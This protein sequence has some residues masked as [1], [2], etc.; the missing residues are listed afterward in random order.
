M[1]LNEHEITHLKN[2]YTCLA[3]CL[4]L[5]KKNGDFPL[6]K[7]GEIALYGSGARQTVK[8]GTGSGEV[9]SRYFVNCEEGLENRGFTVVT[10][11]W[12]DEYDEIRKKMRADFIADIKKKARKHH[13]SV[14]GE[15]MGKVMLEGDYQL[16]IEAQCETAVYVL[17]RISGEGNDRKAE[18]GDFL[19]SE[20]EKKDLYILHQ[21]YKKLL[22]VINAGG[23]VDLSE[24]DFVD[25]ILV[26]SQLGV[27]TG[28]VLADFIL[29]KVYPS[30][31]LATTW[32]AYDNYCHEGDFGDHDDTHY[33]EGIYVG[34]RYFDS[35]G[36]K[37]MYPFGYGL[38]YADFSFET[39]DI[40]ID[41]TDVKVK[42]NVKNDSDRFAGK[43]A[44][45]I[46]VS[47]PQGRID[48][49]YQD[50]TA[51]KKTDEIL[52]GESNE[53]EISFPFTDLTS[54]DSDNHCYVL[55]K[56]DYIIRCGNSS[57]NT[58]I[59]GVIR[60]EEDV[61]TKIVKNCLGDPGF[62]DVIYERKEEEL[63][64][65]V[66]VL[67]IDLHNFKTET[68]NYDVEDEV[69]PELEDC[70]DESLAYLNIGAFN[71]KGGLLNVVGNAGVSVAGAAGETVSLFKDKGLKNIVMADGPAGLRLAKQYYVDTKGVHGVNA[72]LPESVTEYLPGIA[73]WFLK[74][75]NRTPK[76][77]E[78]F[79]QAC[80][81]IPIGTAI[82]Q[83]FNT[84]YA[85]MLGDI[86]GKEM[87]MFKIDLWLAPALNI[88]RNV[89]CGRN[90][91]YFSEDPLVSGK[92]AASITKGVQRHIGK[93]V[94]IK[95][96]AANNQENNRYGNNSLVSERAMREIYL[97][98]FEICIKEA[99]PFAIMSSYNLLNGIHTSEHMGLC[100]DILRREFGF[101]KILMTDWITGMSFLTKNNIYDDPNAA[102]VVRSSHSLFMP[103]CK[104]DYKQ[105][106]DGLKDGTIDS[107]QLKI[108]GSRLFKVY[109]N[110]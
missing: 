84:D 38:G 19:L 24:V 33:K 23:P 15:S 4:V 7:P 59:A 31:K 27:E 75:I 94:T 100:V 69:V 54:Y 77:V 98:G 28:N 90:F 11:K 110:R 65:D 58:K 32:D 81:A 66:K 72:N 82:A 56:G 18:R 99:D 83:T 101:D 35:A 2:I 71:P 49:A 74:L 6:D 109:G 21:K 52:P 13:I 63:P 92:M 8:G 105:I 51:F 86:V 40:S 73:R 106:M 20:T 68:V 30:G 107:R 12:L 78:V 29:G 91:E 62:K 80:T 67:T 26:L 104:K 79:E 44:I 61:V 53:L 45:Q 37:A 17:G 70:D 39:K 57:A 108:N 34:Y 14:I 60:L 22:L 85:Y 36:K 64:D 10:K 3:E 25:N 46:Y 76:N 103:G 5:L 97:K 93:G 95:H 43:E 48:K 96:Y 50:L 1:E 9:N 102:K 47:K 16:P 89:L 87:E 55:E 41:G 42:V 88:H